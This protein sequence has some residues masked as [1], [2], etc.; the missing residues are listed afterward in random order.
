MGI[1][2]ANDPMRLA[3]F[4]GEEIAAAL[5]FCDNDR[6]K[7]LAW[8]KKKQNG[9]GG[10][11]WQEALKTALPAMQA[12]PRVKEC[13]T[14]I[15]EYDNVPLKPKQ[16][17]NFVKNSLALQRDQATVDAMWEAF[18]PLVKKPPQPAAKPKPAAAPAPAKRKRQEDVAAP[19]A[20]KKKT[21]KAE[22]GGAQFGKEERKELK[23]LK[24][25]KMEAGSLGKEDKARLKQLKAAKKA[26]KQ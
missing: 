10:V 7:S 4:S 8:L 21:K 3:G 1:G 9:K 6:Q 14:W 16:F 15:L 5:E 18:A 17:K 2:G 19:P 11:R 24:A 25:A 23:R 26:S 22:K 13:L 12:A 20:E